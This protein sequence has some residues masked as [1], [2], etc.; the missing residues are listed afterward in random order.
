MSSMNGNQPTPV[1]VLFDGTT[2]ENRDEWTK[3]IITWEEGQLAWHTALSPSG[4]RAIKYGL[5]KLLGPEEGIYEGQGDWAKGAKIARKT[6]T[7]SSQS[8]CARGS[9]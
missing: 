2:T 9:S 8:R 5:R 1:Y 7:G 6:L 4:R 3:A